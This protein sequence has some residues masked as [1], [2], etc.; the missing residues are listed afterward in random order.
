MLNLRSS[1]KHVPRRSK[2]ASKRQVRVELGKNSNFTVLGEVEFE[3]TGG[4]LQSGEAERL[5]LMVGMRIYAENHQYMH[6]RPE[7]AKLTY[8]KH[9]AMNRQSGWAQELPKYAECLQTTSG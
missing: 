5:T 3:R 2:N 8:Q 9:K 4:L 7:T 1:A 6:R